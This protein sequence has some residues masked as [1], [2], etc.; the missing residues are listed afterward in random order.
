MLPDRKRKAVKSA[1]EQVSI[2]GMKFERT[3]PNPKP[4][5]NP[6]SRHEI[7]EDGRGPISEIRFYEPFNEG[8]SHLGHDPRGTERHLRPPGDPKHYRSVYG[9]V[10]GSV[11]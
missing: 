5:P 4:K 2:Q 6:H 3:S 8:Q 1:M 10:Y 9:S 11:F 7:R